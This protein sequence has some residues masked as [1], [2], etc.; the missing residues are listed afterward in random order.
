MDMLPTLAAI[1][2]GK[3]PQDRRIDGHD[4]RP[5]L[6]GEPDAKTPYD[7]FYYYYVN[8]LQAVRSGSW[9]LYLPSER[10]M[11]SFGSRSAPAKGELYDL[12]ADP[13]EARNQF[14]DRPDVVERLTALAEKAREDL[15]ELDRRGANVRPVG[16]VE[17]PTP[18]VLPA[19][20]E[21]P[22]TP[23]R[24]ASEGN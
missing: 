2:G 16:V 5:L 21:T 22:S 10:R 23:A 19:S 7:V 6:Y 12:A 17:H 4:I 3:A 15:G 1:G 13:R 9:K 11:T 20:N 24:N 8:Q 18:R 14:A